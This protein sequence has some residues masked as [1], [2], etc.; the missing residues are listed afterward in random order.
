MSRFIPD[1]P[2]PPN[3]FV[4]DAI[5]VSDIDGTKSRR[6]Y[7]GVA[8]EI[9]KINDIDGVKPKTWKVR[10]LFLTSSQEI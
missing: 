2:A 4:R 6:F 3:K 9:L 1:P 5:D 8:K 7:S 10:E